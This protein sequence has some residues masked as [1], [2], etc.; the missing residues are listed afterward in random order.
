MGLPGDEFIGGMRKGGCSEQKILR[1][2]YKYFI[3]IK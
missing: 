3:G 2:E 1:G